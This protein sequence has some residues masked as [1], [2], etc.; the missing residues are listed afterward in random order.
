MASTPKDVID[1]L[2]R[3]ISVDANSFILDF[4]DDVVKQTPVRTGRARSGWQQIDTYKP[5]GKSRTVIINKV[6]Y[7][8]VLDTEHTSKQAPDGI[9]EPAFNAAQRRRK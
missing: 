5:D 2:G 6:P 7:V 3:K 8:G 9:V 1:D 4:K